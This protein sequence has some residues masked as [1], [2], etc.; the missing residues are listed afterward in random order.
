M[1]TF[2]RAVTAILI[3]IMIMI[4]ATGCMQNKN[5]KVDKN[6]M[7]SYMEKKYNDEF[8]YVDSFGGSYDGTS[9]QILVSSKNLPNNRITVGYYFV[10]GREYYTDNYMQ[11]KYLEQTRNHLVSLFK[12]AIGFD[13][14]VAYGVSSTGIKN[15]F[16]DSTSF[17]EFIKSSDNRLLFNI[18]VSPECDVINTKEK[19]A[20]DLKKAIE[21]NLIT[22]V[23]DIYFAD[24]QDNFK[25]FEDLTSS[26]LATM[27]KLSIVMDGKSSFSKFEWR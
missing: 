14:L 26:E 5:N 12:D 13:V 18:V 23:T 1:S 22:C 16:D 9:Y 4:G 21:E 6:A 10:D 24:S 7:I 3:T 20:S 15:N 17:E 25:A 27:T 8:T 19:I 2:I 11:Y